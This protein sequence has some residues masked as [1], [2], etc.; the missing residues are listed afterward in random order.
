MCVPDYLRGYPAAWAADPAPLDPAPGILK[1]GP[2]PD[3]DAQ[4]IVAFLWCGGMRKGDEP[5]RYRSQ[6]VP[7]SIVRSSSYEN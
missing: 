4:S 6:R 3:L 1:I 7:P 2:R 5:H